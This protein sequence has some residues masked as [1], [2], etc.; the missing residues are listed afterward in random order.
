MRRLHPTV[1]VCDVP[2]DY[3]PDPEGTADE[4]ADAD[5]D[6][7]SLG[8]EEARASPETSSGTGR[9]TDDA[10]ISHQV[11]DAVQAG[12]VG[13]VDGVA[14]GVEVGVGFLAGGSGWVKRP[15]VGS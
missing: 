2:P 7:A 15:R 11:V 13:V 3:H 4:A 6:S 10:D 14:G 8:T 5:S 12:G 1:S 9:S